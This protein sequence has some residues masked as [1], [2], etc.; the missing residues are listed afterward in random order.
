M[1][2]E[3]NQKKITILNPASS[4]EVGSI[5]LSTKLDVENALIT[6]NDYKEWSSLS[7][8]KRCYLINKFRKAVFKNSDS[9]KKKIK[10]ETGKKDFVVF[11]E[12]LSFLDHAKTMSKLARTALKKDKRKTGLLFKNKKAYVQYEPLGVV[13]IISPWNF[14]L[15][16]PMKGVIEGLLAGNNI[17][18]K[19]SE[20]TP[21]TIQVIKKIWDEN[22][23]YNDA[24]QVVNGLGQIGAMLVE[25][26]LTDVICFTGSTEVGIKI[27]EIC[28]K[29]LKP[30]VLELG[31][32]DP[33]IILKDAPLK[34]SV[35]SALHAGLFNAGQTCISTEEVYVEEELMD[36]FVSKLSDR[37]KVIKSGSDEKDD[38][39][40]IITPETKKKIEDHI[41]GVKDSCDIYRGTNSGGGNYIAPTIVI[42]P[43]ESSKIVNEETFGPVMSIKSFKN[44]DELVKRIH[45]TGYGLSSSIFGRDKKRIN[46]IIKRMK[47][48]NVNIN[49]A[50]TSYAIPSL[51][52]GGE[53]ISGLGKQHGIEGLRSYCRIKSVVVNRFN[54][55]D[56][57]TWWGRPKIIEKFLEKAVNLL[58]R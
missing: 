44:E 11:V 47:T 15:T 5:D 55:I 43:P 41:N 17:V 51:P 40:P 27:A 42:N 9:I 38:L 8:K 46:S 21:L 19:P 37:I 35:E 34:R 36:E 56:E 3:I 10:D 24:F 58:F 31:G 33:M 57:P 18:L 16:T 48:G 26:D 39:G 45:K 20:Y 22:I 7:L 29:T 13:G 25:S 23:G 4:N 2:I 6:A 30:C 32:K 14:P 12:F 52:Y 28:S 50:M 1:P 54:F 49:D 53:G